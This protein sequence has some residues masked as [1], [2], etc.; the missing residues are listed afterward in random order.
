MFTETGETPPPQDG[1]RQL[2]RKEQQ[3]AKRDAQKKAQPASAVAQKKTPG[4]RGKNWT[5]PEKLCGVYS[6]T[7]V[8]AEFCDGL[9]QQERFVHYNRVY[10]TEAQRM[11]KN[12]EWVDQHGRA[13]DTITFEQSILERCQPVTTATKS[14]PISTMVE[15]VIRLVRNH[16]APLMSKLLDA[17]GQIRTGEQQADVKE[18]LRLEY[19]DNLHDKK[20]AA[21]GKRA[22]KAKGGNGLS[23]GTTSDNEAEGD[24]P[25][26]HGKEAADDLM[27]AVK[28]QAAKDR[29]H[30][31]DLYLYFHFGPAVIGGSNNIA[32]L[33]D[34]QAMQ[35]A[36][37]K[38]GGGGRAKHR[39]ERQDEKEGGARAAKIHKADSTLSQQLCGTP[40]SCSSPS[41]LYCGA[42][43][44][45]DKTSAYFL[46]EQKAK[47]DKKWQEHDMLLGRMVLSP[48]YICW[49]PPLPP[50]LTC[51]RYRA[52]CSCLTWSV[53]GCRREAHPVC[54]QRRRE[55]SMPAGTRTACPEFCTQVFA[56]PKTCSWHASPGPGLRVP[57]ARPPAVRLVHLLHH[58]YHG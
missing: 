53:T 13:V 50:P 32:F 1:A 4:A 18:K 35:E 10:T 15:G 52:Q 5:F 47:L 22:S 49:V 40:G 26:G 17:R 58:V 7:S 8:N 11:W 20:I 25:Q 38:N 57:G 36:V 29:F 6:V 31:D 9:P 55:T 56:A 34:A 48:M 44:A 43:G 37:A 19:F 51:V 27:D 28:L 21:A 45:G 2:A 46:A 3:Q 14:S 33:R 54:A 41:P 42:G 23:S 24:S 12:G 30:P 16:L 39:Q